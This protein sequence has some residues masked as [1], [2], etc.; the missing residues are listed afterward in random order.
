MGRINLSSLLESFQI[1]LQV[2]KGLSPLTV[3]AYQH[4]VSLYLEFLLQKKIDFLSQITN[5]LVY[6]FLVARVQEDQLNEFSQARN[7]S[8]IRSFHRF[9][10]ITEQLSDDPTELL[11]SP[12][13]VRKLPT[14]LSPEEVEMILSTIDLSEPL[15]IRN[16]AMIELLYSSGLRVSELTG[17]S[18]RNYFPQEGFVRILG[19][20]EKE[21]LVPVGAY[22]IKY[23][24]QYLEF[25]RPT[26]PIKPGHSQILFLNRRGTPLTRMMVFYIIRDL[27]RLAG[28]QKPVSPHTF[29][30]SF[31]TVLLE[32]GA[33]L[34]A[35][36]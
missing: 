15:G 13:L 24:A 33:D 19:K 27:A 12:K 35:I 8:S 25:V 4:D 2:E 32:N 36:Q 30:H 9:L 22:A 23:I 1:H 17:L 31:A 18:L 29:R 28:I 3:E 20:G 6:E 5:E 10:V 11:S 14:V 26:F 16:R 21:R 7:L 34:K